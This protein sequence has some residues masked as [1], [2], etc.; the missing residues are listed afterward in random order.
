VTFPRKQLLQSQ[1]ELILADRLART[2]A[3]FDPE[4]HAGIRAL[5]L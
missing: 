5:V 2:R 3:A 1:Y 4:T